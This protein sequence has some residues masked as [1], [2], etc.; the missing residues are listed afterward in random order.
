MAEFTRVLAPGGRL[1]MNEFFIKD[2]TITVRYCRSG[3]TPVVAT[4][5]SPKQ[6]DRDMR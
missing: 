4:V 2:D 5:R 6:L 3:R 1:G